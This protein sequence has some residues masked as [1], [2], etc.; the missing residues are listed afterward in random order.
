MIPHIFFQFSGI[1]FEWFLPNSKVKCRCYIQKNVFGEVVEGW[2]LRYEKGGVNPNTTSWGEN[3]NIC[4]I[5]GI[6]DWKD[7][8]FELLYFSIKMFYPGNQTSYFL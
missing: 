6:S 3:W 7:H 4:E 2:S 1:I 8:I 5:F